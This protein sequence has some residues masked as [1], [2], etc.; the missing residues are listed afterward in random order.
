MWELQQRFHLAAHSSL[1]F[2]SLMVE[3]NTHFLNL[4]FRVSLLPERP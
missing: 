1:A 3:S 2:V 4:I